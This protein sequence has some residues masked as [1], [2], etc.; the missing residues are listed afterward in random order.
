MW[1]NLIG[2]LEVIGIHS[3][4][5]I[6]KEREKE[7]PVTLICSLSLSLSNSLFFLYSIFLFPPQ[8]TTLFPSKISNTASAMC[9]LAIKFRFEP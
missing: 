5:S 2:Q 1:R 4:V 3:S 8:F 6:K 7:K 9:D